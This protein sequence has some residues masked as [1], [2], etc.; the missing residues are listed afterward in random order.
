M[1]LNLGFPGHIATR[2]YGRKTWAGHPCMGGSVG[3]CLKSGAWG[4][5]E[6]CLF[7]EH[8]HSKGLDLPV[9]KHLSAQDW[10][11][12]RGGFCCFWCLNKT[13]TPSPLGA[14][15]T[16][17]IVKN[18]LEMRKFWPL[19]VKRSRTKITYHQTPPQRSVLKHS[20]HSKH[21]NML[22]YC[23][24][25]SKMIRRTS[26][27]APMHFQSFKVNKKKESYEVWK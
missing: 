5:A 17:T 22:L 11:D 19:K 6:G 16:L 24:Q 15:D 25:S 18:G 1:I 14:F 12:P 27:D 4:G 3:Q 21:S 13:W 7:Q 23:Y 9:T 8:P 10:P 2:L 20:K 26:G